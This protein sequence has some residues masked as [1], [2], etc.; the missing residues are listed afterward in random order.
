[1]TPFFFFC[2]GKDLFRIFNHMVGFF[3]I[4]TG[5]KLIDLNVIFWGSTIIRLS[6][7]TSKIWLVVI[8][9]PYLGLP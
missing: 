4:C 1:M 9:N 8:S 5:L 7:V 6:L 3:E 2:L